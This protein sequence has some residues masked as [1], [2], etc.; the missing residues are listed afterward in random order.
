LVFVVPYLPRRDRRPRIDQHWEDLDMRERSGTYPGARSALDGRRGRLLI[1]ALLGVLTLLI[2]A[3]SGTTA[4]PAALV[5]PRHAASIARLSITPATGDTN[6]RPDQGVTVSAARGLIKSVTVT[7]GADPLSGALNA[8]H[9]VWHTTWALLPSHYYVVT[10]T[11]VDSKGRPVTQRSSFRTL[12]PRATFQTQIFEGYH[13]TYGVGMP[14]ILTFSHPVTDKIAVEQSLQLWTSKP[15]VGAWYWDGSESLV[16]RPRTYWP[17][18]THVSVVAHLDGV[19][20]APGVY[21][22]ANLTQSF[23]IGNSL[24]AVVSTASHY[25]AIYYRD[26]LFG[27]W[28]VSTGEPG[29]DTANGTYLTIEKANPV[30]M[31]GPGYTDFPVPYSVR[32]TWS[33]DYMH[34]AYWSVG[35][36]GYTNVSHGCVNLSPAHAEIYYDLAVPGDPVT[37][38]GSPVAGAWDDGWTEWFLTWSQWLHGSATHDAVQAGPSGSTF[39]NPASLSPAA[40]RAP[41]GAPHP[42]NYLAS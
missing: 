29:D 9:T 41:L 26:K 23:Y 17:Q 31:S 32:F 40:A 18:H 14:I 20:A 3:C 13:Q 35:E 10:A 1:T 39:V 5:K 7:T 22:T 12:T 16:F 19:E 25:A 2:A 38:K 11:A 15:I 42:G 33:G 6:A 8:A 27:V 21:G 37:I 28:P 34:D 24:I 4:R 36:Q 30:L